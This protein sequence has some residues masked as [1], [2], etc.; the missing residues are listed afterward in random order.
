MNRNKIYVFLILTL[1][2]SWTNWFIGLNCLSDGINQESIGKFLVFFF[3]GVYGGFIQAGVGFI[4]LLVLSS[5]NNFTLVKSNAI[6]VF[7]T[8]VFTIGSIGI[9]I[10]NDNVLQLKVITVKV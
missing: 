1:L 3:V 10:F 6:K 9:F 2:W 5:I 7:V 8:L 4:M